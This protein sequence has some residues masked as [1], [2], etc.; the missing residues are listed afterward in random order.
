MINR[1]DYFSMKNGFKAKLPFSDS[2]YKNRQ[3]KL[4]QVM[5]KNNVD[6]NRAIEILQMYGYTQF[7]QV[8]KTETKAPPFLK[9]KK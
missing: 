5:D 8:T 2:E 6:R 3:E 4:K 7:P 1:A 9:G